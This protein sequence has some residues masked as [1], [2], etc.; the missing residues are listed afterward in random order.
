MK[1]FLLFFPEKLSRWYWIV[2]LFV[3]EFLFLWGFNG[4]FPF[5]IIKLKALSGGTGI[6]DEL[7]YYNFHQ[8]YHLFDSYGNWGRSMYL[9]LQTIDMIYPIIYSLLLG[10]LLSL[11]YKRTRFD[12]LILLPFFAMIFD[13]GENILLY[14]NITQ[15]P[16]MNLT[17]VHLAGLSTMLKWTLVMLSVFSLAIGIIAKIILLQRKRIRI[18]KQGES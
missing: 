13:Y 4:M 11:F 9:R 15:F 7:Y 3:L 18:G 8:L 12:W 6:P 14:I 1:D 16:N 17:L 2:L 5:S 10:S